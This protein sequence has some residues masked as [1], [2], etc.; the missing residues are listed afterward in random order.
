MK[1]NRTLVYEFIVKCTSAVTAEEA[2]GVSTQ[3]LSERLHMQRTNISSILNQLVK[4]GTI[5]KLNGRPVLYRV[6]QTGSSP[7]E[8]VS[9]FC[10]LV[11]C[12]GSLKNSVQLAKAAILY[13]KRSLHSLILGASGSGKSTFASLMYQFAKENMV[14]KEN[15]PYV[16]FNCLNYHDNPLQMEQELFGPGEDSRLR[17]AEGGV[18]FIDN[19][20]FLPAT[21]RNSL[22]RM[23]ESNT[24]ETDGG[25]RELQVIIICAMNDN[26]T[27]S[28]IENYSKY[29]FIKIQMP[30]LSERTFPERFQMI[31][32]FFTIEAERSNK[33]IQISTEILMGLLL[34]PCEWNVKQLQKDIQLGCANAYAREYHTAK[35]C[36]TVLMSDFPYCVRT[37]FLNFKHYQTE[38]KEIISV[39]CS[40]AFSKEKG[41][42]IS[43]KHADK[44]EKKSMY[45]WIDK[46]ANE[47]RSRGIEERDINLILSIDIE[48][49]FKQYSNR[50][51][52][53][54]VDKEQL[55]QIVDKKIVSSVS[56]FLEE[57]TARFNKVYPVSIFYGLCLHLSATL[58]KNNRSQ[59]LSNEQ[60]M[61]I[62][63]NNGNEYGYCLKYIGKLEEEFKTKLAID[64]VVFL[65]LFLTKDPVAQEAVPRPVV[66]IALHGDSAAKSIVE[67]VNRM[68]GYPAYAFD[69]S[70][71]KEVKAAY[72]ELKALILK[73][74]QGKGVFVLYDMGSFETMFDV[75]SKE[76]GIA[77]RTIEIPLTLLALEC[78]RKVQIGMSLDEIYE[79]V[80]INFQELSERK[81]EVPN[82]IREKNVILTMCMSGEGAALQIKNY[83]EKHLEHKQIRVIPISYA[84]K[85]TMLEEINRIKE[86]HNIICIVGSHDPQLIGIRY[87]SVVDIFQ[88]NMKEL[89]SVI[90]LFLSSDDLSSEYVDD[91]EVI[92]EHLGE[93]LHL[94]DIKKLK[95][96]LPAALREFEEKAECYL[97]KEQELALMIH[98][99]CCMEHI[100]EGRDMPINR[101]KNEVIRE[102]HRLYE[103]LRSSFQVLERE[104][105]ITFDENE[106]ANIISII[107]ISQEGRASHL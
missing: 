67:V 41:I 42:L 54:I 96:S 21:A 39:N 85:K 73:I 95:T 49:E 62:I 98:I 75:I 33:T 91:F 100:L 17:K 18:L 47:L 31:Q 26:A 78:S 81:M 99:A 40:Y 102:N 92:F 55:A 51:G 34:Y 28:L 77:I 97:M 61:E 43:E 6:K 68:S 12:G 37:G 94:I 4:E 7:E 63:K 64:E 103:E 32:R 80:K 52:E 58:G 88:N 79:D 60:I 46:K 1:S 57:A 30:L 38:I 13:P 87:I 83:V 9:C 19:I 44:D 107:K 53:Q 59:R 10:Q 8:E 66:L 82:R 3:Y 90:S 101:N 72:E 2:R 105:G 93:E 29:F 36:I 86:E 71:D 45:D 16:R 84:N 104:F 23:V 69:M 89:K 65:T 76:T 56:E 50:L 35:E 74:H 48:N 5:E 70:L 15:A 106:F 27:R 11:G 14:I 20:E 22:M 24:V 25:K